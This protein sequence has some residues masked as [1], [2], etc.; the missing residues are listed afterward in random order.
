MSEGS[1]RTERAV[2]TRVREG[3]GLF[4]RSGRGLIEVSGAD[5]VRWLD[6]MLTQNVKQLVE[7]GEGAGCHALFLTHR[8]A[9]V[10]DLRVG[11][12]GESILLECERSGVP[13]IRA[14]L[15]KRIIADEVVLTDRS[16][17]FEAIGLEGAGAPAVFARA[18][19]GGGRLERDAF[20][21][22]RVG[23]AEVLVAAIGWS[24]E[25]AYQFHC[26]PGSRAAVRAA[27]ERAAAELGIDCVAG[28]A[29]LEEVLRIEAGIPRAGAELDEEVLPPE[30]RLEATIATNKGCY[31]G[32]EIVARLR[33]R[34]QV[35][36]LLVGLR[37]EEG[38]RPS[39]GAR[40][41]VEGRSVGELSSVA[42][43]PTEGVLALGFVRR[44]HAEVG[45]RLDL[46]GDG[47]LV[48]RVV[49]VALP[50]VSLRSCAAGAQDRDAALSP[51][52]RARGA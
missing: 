13:R 4:D 50:F 26:T 48:G 17:D 25:D 34:G 45:R 40:L 29:V 51:P 27:L 28:D 5:R 33:S 35:N 21:R 7:R 42:V 9:I 15:E 31:V 44:E 3:V 46:E 41:V 22:G 1:V 30:A 6:G 8:G 23:G 43:S 2:T 52:D 32:Q 10:A 14:A 19:E 47:A 37:P 36:H 49:V 39:V 18:L 12:V 11:V 24:G 38:I 16:D 20:L